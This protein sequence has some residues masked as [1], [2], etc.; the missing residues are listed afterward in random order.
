MINEKNNMRTEAL[1]NDDKTHR[2]IL[3]KAWDNN[4]PSVSII[5][6][7]PS[8]KAGEVRIDMTSMYVIN[9]CFQQGF[10]SVEIL[11]LYSKL[12]N[13][14]FES[15]RENDDQILRSCQKAEKVIL[16]WGKGQSQKMVDKRIEEVLALLKLYQ[17]KLYEIADRSGKAG[18]HPLGT[19]VRLQWHLVPYQYPQTI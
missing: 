2:Y 17:D 5:M 19:S 4:K 3:K 10:G 8:S 15:C 12:E 9:N 18:L 16:A 13:G 1:Y 6:I 11:N 14:C 7:A